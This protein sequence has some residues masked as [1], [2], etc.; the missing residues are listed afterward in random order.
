M[1]RPGNRR[2]P[3]LL[4]WMLLM[5]PNLGD[6]ISWLLQPII[7]A[8]LILAVFGL[9]P[10]TVGERL[11]GHYLDQRLASAR[12]EQNE[13][14]EELEAQLA[15]LGDTGVRSNE[16]EYFALVPSSDG[17]APPIRPAQGP[18]SVP[19]PP[20]SDT[21]ALIP[22]P[23]IADP[24]PALM[25]PQPDAAPTPAPPLPTVSPAALT[26][27]PAPIPSPTRHM[28]VAQ[29]IGESSET[30]A[31]S[32]FLQMQRELPSALG[33]HE[34]AILRTTLKDGTI[35]ARV[36]VEFDT[37][38]AAEALCSKLEAARKPCLVQRN[39]DNAR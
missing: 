17:S 23:Q 36:R 39:S 29:L 15:H 21:T 37:P 34:P 35:W 31:L 20:T 38:Q 1:S 6:L 26:T 14:I 18:A 2:A 11:F 9:A 12:H 33:S 19:T 25:P 3:N 28:W 13:R 4:P 10:A 16:R 5:Q 8:G 32:R 22:M 27:S 7:A 30:V 24:A